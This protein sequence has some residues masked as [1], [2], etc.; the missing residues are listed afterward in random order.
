MYILN[1]VSTI[2]IEGYNIYSNQQVS[3]RKIYPD[4]DKN[5]KNS[6]NCHVTEP[7]T[8]PNPVGLLGMLSRA[9]FQ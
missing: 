9:T 8:L 6:T 3:A 7:V 2:L 5:V 1:L 4:G